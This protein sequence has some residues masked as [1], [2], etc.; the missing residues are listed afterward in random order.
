MTRLGKILPDTVLA[1]G[2]KIIIKNTNAPS[3]KTSKTKST[4]HTGFFNFIRVEG[5]DTPH[6]RA[7]PIY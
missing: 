5:F 4:V 7:P 1:N 3:L 2:E 6:F